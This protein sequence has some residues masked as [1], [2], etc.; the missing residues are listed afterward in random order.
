MKQYNN[1]VAGREAFV[2]AGKGYHAST[3]CVHKGCNAHPFVCT[4]EKC[5]CQ[6]PHLTHFRMGL[7][8]F[9]ESLEES[10]RLPNEWQ[11]IKG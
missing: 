8:G 7:Q 5:S 10:P 9:R 2:C 3:V 11:H 6:R 1:N 4:D